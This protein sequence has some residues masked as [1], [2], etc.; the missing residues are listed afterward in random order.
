MLPPRRTR[1]VLRSPSAPRR[2][3]SVPIG[4]ELRARLGE[5]GRAG[6]RTMLAVTGGVNTHRGA[7]WA[8]GLLSAGAA[9][10]ARRRRRRC[11][12]PGGDP[13]PTR[14]RR[15]PSHGA[16]VRRRYGVSGATGEAQAGFPHVRL[17]ALP[18]LRAARR[19]GADEAS[20]RLDALLALMAPGRHL[21]P[22]PRR[23]R[24]AARVQSGA[25]AVLAAGG[26]GTRRAGDA[27][28]HSTTCACTAIVA[29]RQRRS[30]VRHA[31]SRCPRRERS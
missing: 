26:I 8:L 18:A 22:A 15:A 27:S 16:Q 23:P 4:T 25:Q 7:L 17:H 13:R 20:A 21:R 11:G 30:V 10:G 19:S 28:P 6:E 31:V 2:H 1:C 3:E 29:W 12:A 14:R 9:P 5:I 24:R